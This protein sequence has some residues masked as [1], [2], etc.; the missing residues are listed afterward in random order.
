MPPSCQYPTIWAF[1]D[2]QDK[3][4]HLQYIANVF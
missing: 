1:D 2:S 4:N 3:D